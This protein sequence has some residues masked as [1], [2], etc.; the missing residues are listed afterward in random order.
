MVG[1]SAQSVLESS[2][3]FNEEITFANVSIASIDSAISSYTIKTN[4]VVIKPSATSD[5]TSQQPII[6]GSYVVYNNT[7]YYVVGSYL[8][9]DIDFTSTPIVDSINYLVS[10]SVVIFETSN[11]PSTAGELTI[12][13]VNKVGYKFVVESDFDLLT[14]I[15]GGY[16]ISYIVSTIE[17]DES[18]GGGADD[19]V[20]GEIVKNLT[21]IRTVGGTVSPQ[22]HVYSE[23]FPI[24]NITLKPYEN[25]TFIGL[26]INGEYVENSYNNLTLEVDLST[27]SRDIVV[28]AKFAKNVAIEFRIAVDNNESKEYIGSI[29]EGNLLKELFINGTI[30]NIYNSIN[31]SYVLGDDFFE[32]SS[33][34]TDI[35]IQANK[36]NLMFTITVP[37][38][39]KLHFGV[40][41]DKV[42]V[43]PSPTAYHFNGWYLLENES[44]STSTSLVSDDNYFDI[45]AIEKAQYDEHGN[46][47]ANSKKNTLSFVA[48]YSLDTTK[49]LLVTTSKVQVHAYDDTTYGFTTKEYDY[50]EFLANGTINSSLE[51]NNY[52]A[53]VDAETG[54]TYLF[55][56]WWQEINKD[57]SVLISSN[58]D[59]T[60]ALQGNC[61]ARFIEYRAITIDY[62]ED[63]SI[64]LEGNMHMSY[65]Y[66]QTAGETN[67]LPISVVSGSKIKAY[68]TVFSALTNVVINAENTFLFKGEFDDGHGGTVSKYEVSE[69][70]D[71]EFKLYGANYDDLFT[72][73]SNPAEDT[74]AHIRYKKIYED[75]D[76]YALNLIS[77]NSINQVLVKIQNN[78]NSFKVSIIAENTTISGQESSTQRF[79]AASSIIVVTN[80]ISQNNGLQNQFF[81]NTIKVLYVNNKAYYIYQPT[82]NIQSSIVYK[83]LASFKINQDK[84]SQ[85]AT[86]NDLFI[87]IVDNNNTTK[88]ILADIKDILDNGTTAEK[89]ALLVQLVGTD[90]AKVVITEDNYT[91]YVYYETVLDT[92]LNISARTE[93]YFTI[94]YRDDD[95]ALHEN[96]NVPISSNTIDRYYPRYTYITIT[97]AKEYRTESFVGFRISYDSEN[98]TFY[99]VSD[100]GYSFSFCVTE[101]VTVSAQF[102]NA[103]INVED[104]VTDSTIVS[105]GNG[106][107]ASS[108]SGIY[109]DDDPTNVVTKMIST[110][111]ANDYIHSI[112]MEFSYN[113]AMQIVIFQYDYGCNSFS[114]YSGLPISNIDNDQFKVSGLDYLSDSFG[115]KMYQLVELQ[116]PVAAE[117]VTV[118]VITVQYYQLYRMNITVMKNDSVEGCEGYNLNLYYPNDYYD[119]VITDGFALDGEYVNNLKLYQYIKNVL[120]AD[121]AIGMIDPQ[122]DNT[123][124]R[125]SQ[126]MT[127]NDFIDGFY[128]YTNETNSS[129]FKISGKKVMDDG[130][131][132]HY[133]GNVKTLVSGT[134]AYTLV[135]KFKT[136]GT[137]RIYVHPSYY[138]N[139][140]YSFTETNS[141][142]LPSITEYQMLMGSVLVGN[143][144]TGNNYQIAYSASES[145]LDYSIKRDVTANAGGE[146]PNFNKGVYYFDITYYFAEA[147]TIYFKSEYLAF[148][149]YYYQSSAS[150]YSSLHTALPTYP[151]IQLIDFGTNNSA[152]TMS[153]QEFVD[154]RSR[155]YGYANGDTDKLILH[156]DAKESIKATTLRFNFEENA[157]LGSVNPQVAINLSQGA[158]TFVPNDGNV[159]TYLSSDST[160]RT[161]TFTKTGSTDEI[162]ISYYSYTDTAHANQNCIKII[163]STDL[164]NKQTKFDVELL[165]FVVKYQFSGTDS[166]RARIEVVDF[167]KYSL[168]FK[169]VYCLNASQVVTKE[170]VSLSVGNHSKIYWTL[171]STFADNNEIVIET[172][173]CFYTLFS[174]DKAQTTGTSGEYLNGTDEVYKIMLSMYEDGKVGPTEV[175]A[176]SSTLKNLSIY[177]YV[178][179][180][181]AISVDAPGADSIFYADPSKALGSYTGVHTVNEASIT[182]DNV[183]SSLQTGSFV[184]Y[185]TGNVS[186]VNSLAN[187]Y[188]F[189]KGPDDGNANT[190]ESNGIFFSLTNVTTSSISYM[191]HPNTSRFYLA[192]YNGF[193]SSSSNK[194]ITGILAPGNSAHYETSGDF[195]TLSQSGANDNNFNFIFGIANRNDD[196]SYTQNASNE[197]FIYAQTEAFESHDSLYLDEGF[198]DPADRSS[199]M[200][201]TTFGNTEMTY[202]IYGGAVQYDILIKATIK[203]NKISSGYY[204]SSSLPAKTTFTELDYLYDATGNNIYEIVATPESGSYS[205]YYKIGTS[206]QYQVLNQAESSTSVAY[207]KVTTVP[208]GRMHALTLN[209]NGKEVFFIDGKIYTS[210]TFENGEAKL[211][212]S[213]TKDYTPAIDCLFFSVNYTEKTVQYSHTNTIEIAPYSVAVYKLKF[214]FGA[215]YVYGYDGGVLKLKKNGS[216]VNSGYSI[217]Y[218]NGLVLTL[219][220]GTS[221]QA[222]GVTVENPQAPEI[223]NCYTEAQISE[224]PEG[225]NYVKKTIKASIYDATYRELTFDSAKSKLIPIDEDTSLDSRVEIKYDAEIRKSVYYV[226][227]KDTSTSEIYRY[228]LKGNKLYTSYDCLTEANYTSD[229]TSYYGSGFNI[230]VYYKS[231]NVG[232]IN[233]ARKSATISGSGEIEYKKDTISGNEF[234]YKSSD[235]K[236]YLKGQAS[237]YTG[238]YSLENAFIVVTRGNGTTLSIDAKTEEIKVNTLYAADDTGFKYYVGGNSLYVDYPFENKTKVDTSSNHKYDYNGG[239]PK[240][241]ILD[242]LER[243]RYHIASYIIYPATIKYNGL[244]YTPQETSLTSSSSRVDYKAGSETI[245]YEPSTQKVYTSSSVL[246]PTDQLSLSKSYKVCYSIKNETYYSFPTTITYITGTEILTLSLTNDISLVNEKLV[247][248]EDG[249]GTKYR[250][251]VETT[252]LYLVNA[253]TTTTLINQNKYIL[254]SELRYICITSGAPSETYKNIKASTAADFIGDIVTETVVGNG[255]VPYTSAKVKSITTSAYD[256][257]YLKGF[258]V[259]TDVNIAASNSMW[260]NYKEDAGAS[261]PL[262]GLQNYAYLS[263]FEYCTFFS[264]DYE[265][266]KNNAVDTPFTFER[267]ANGVI[268]SITFNCSIPIFGNLKIF[269]VYS[270]IIYSIDV[271]QINLQQKP[272]INGEPVSDEGVVG[273]ADGKYPLTTLYRYYF[274]ANYDEA[275]CGYVKGQ[276][277]VEYEGDAWIKARAYNGN[278]FLGYSIGKKSTLTT[279]N[280]VFAPN[281]VENG[282]DISEIKEAVTSGASYADTEEYN[283]AMLNK[284]TS[285]TPSTQYNE[286]YFLDD[287]VMKY[288][289]TTNSYIQIDET[290]SK[291]SSNNIFMFAITNDV[292]INFYYKAVQYE[293][294]LEL[295]DIE[296][297]FYTD[298]ESGS[299]EMDTYISYTDEYMEESSKT[300]G[301]GSWTNPAAVDQNNLRQPEFTIPAQSDALA[302]GLNGNTALIINES[303]TPVTYKK[304]DANDSLVYTLYDSTGK[305]LL[306]D[307]NSNVVAQPQPILSRT[308]DWEASDAAGFLVYKEVTGIPATDSATCDRRYIPSITAIQGQSLVRPAGPG[309]E[310]SIKVAGQSLTVNYFTKAYTDSN[311]ANK[312]LLLYTT[313]YKNQLYVVRETLYYH[314]ADMNGS[315]QNAVANVRKATAYYLYKVITYGSMDTYLE[316]NAAYF[317]ENQ[318]GNKSKGLVIDGSI[319]TDTSNGDVRVN[320]NNK[321]IFSIFTI[322]E[323]TDGTFTPVYNSEGKVYHINTDDVVWNTTNVGSA[324]Y[325]FLTFK[326]QVTIDGTAHTMAVIAS[327]GAYADASTFDKDWSKYTAKYISALITQYNANGGDISTNIYKAK[328]D[329]LIQQGIIFVSEVDDVVAENGMRNVSSS[330][331]NRQILDYSTYFVISTD[332]FYRNIYTLKEGLFSINIGGEYTITSDQFT[333]SADM[334]NVSVTSSITG[335]TKQFD[336]GCEITLNP[337]GEGKLVA[338]IKISIKIFYNEQGSLPSVKIYSNTADLKQD[339]YLNTTLYNLTVYGKT[340]DYTHM[341][342]S[343]LIYK[344]VSPDELNGTNGKRSETG[345]SFD[346]R[347]ITSHVE[348][349]SFFGHIYNA[350]APNDEFF[351]L[352]NLN[353]KVSIVY[354]QSLMKVNPQAQFATDEPTKMESQVRD[355]LGTNGRNIYNDSAGS[356]KAT[357]QKMFIANV[358]KGGSGVYT[359]AGVHSEPG[360]IFQ[361]Y[362]LYVISD[363][364]EIMSML[365][366]IYQNKRYS[367]EHRRDAL[368]YMSYINGFNPEN[369]AIASS[370]GGKTVLSYPQYAFSNHGNCKTYE[371]LYTFLRDRGMNLINLPTPEQVTENDREGAKYMRVRSV[372]IMRAAAYGVDSNFVQ[373]HFAQNDIVVSC[374]QLPMMFQRQVMYKSDSWPKVNDYYA[375][376]AYTYYYAANH[377]V[378]CDIENDSFVWSG[379]PADTVLAGTSNNYVENSDGSSE[380]TRQAKLMKS[381]KYV[382][383]QLPSNVFTGLMRL[384][385]TYASH[386]QQNSHV[387]PYYAFVDTSATLSPSDFSKNRTAEGSDVVTGVNMIIFVDDRKFDIEDNQDSYDK[388]TMDNRIIVQVFEFNPEPGYIAAERLMI[389]AMIVGTI[390]LLA[391]SIFTGGTSTA[392]AVAM[393]VSFG[394]GTALYVGGTVSLIYSSCAMR[395]DNLTPEIYQAVLEMYAKGY[396]RQEDGSI[397]FNGLSPDI[398]EDEF[399]NLIPD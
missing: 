123:G 242:D 204:K 388:S 313:T 186:F 341:T 132:Y 107:N 116:Y 7:I 383:S 161:L 345:S 234:V 227:I 18:Y 248:Y 286:V 324:S 379:A 119:T 120:F 385:N 137:I 63:S 296:T 147:L 69:L 3:N 310:G 36:Q 344:P 257:Y 182:T 155:T 336:T 298:P 191:W 188:L 340:V 244:S 387:V 87:E 39:T 333:T 168:E 66:I 252:A 9:E 352:P 326:E 170:N 84:N 265:V 146:N 158:S 160:I 193:E 367:K 342:T 295:G 153:Y 189:L 289:S 255:D 329:L 49:P 138:K 275:S 218:L 8:Y 279:V 192:D 100:V 93:S 215:N 65:G 109:G 12:V 320:T 25:Y 203:G 399:L 299:A 42:E 395:G 270:P 284:I 338:T 221:I 376:H 200:K 339:K 231:I 250:Y 346:T 335:L 302:A 59:E 169:N 72:I 92:E 380:P 16:T 291:G 206:G 239:N 130:E 103:V 238:D 184:N 202:Y 271:S 114:V 143:L 126:T 236:L 75:T 386:L 217:E 290:L 199:S 254:R 124:T 159:L 297:G 166:T 282:T 366:Q 312:E 241:F 211:D 280:T 349:G 319:Y 99:K 398:I 195:G 293:L 98:S 308:I 354:T 288:D 237:A 394:V 301:T 163:Y 362:K 213:L 31:A 83:N 323:Q 274:A 246:I 60:G 101:S 300:S 19:I 21:S 222:S 314:A 397:K 35:K 331:Y 317:E 85:T 51:L 28:E 249:A 152:I 26:Y 61:I 131:N 105:G 396:E 127:T 325:S 201:F 94:T 73:S 225:S 197:A 196:V 260:L 113:G 381:N 52:R 78:Y 258:V 240:G 228:Y 178:R 353:V 276:L 343:D 32:S 368:M 311:G 378:T 110:S 125:F 330:N 259:F 144:N 219:A 304:V 371:E 327:Y 24:L 2:L 128:A 95:N 140:I 251:N 328:Y 149:R 141:A 121:T 20:G 134:V 281:Y 122:I 13:S 70:I 268:L 53:F 173:K 135:Y 118:P 307:E 177:A 112:R 374:V 58:F 5:V 306:N 223:I 358:Y 172:K 214:N 27:Y 80:N 360:F 334:Q 54:A 10:N 230:K 377:Y 294:E 391:A 292:H 361:S 243:A 34:I 165:N 355:M 106:G 263:K 224:L 111:T 17:G 82:K 187:A 266:F 357:I 150:E 148:D 151:Q 50:L 375:D 209:Y 44:I 89:Q 350:G 139:G 176:T 245:K 1:G 210:Y 235:G 318:Y 253:D 81:A 269:A 71:L 183:Y 232:G 76:Q 86:D 233:L 365:N 181:D 337:Y 356:Q 62:T 37:Y 303:S 273:L 97:L 14:I 57:M 285:P 41:N 67:M 29:D 156:L 351:D 46:V 261:P 22:T 332:E 79:N 91:L 278:V 283:H 262:T 264:I 373:R 43:N 164:I 171:G 174:R 133:E 287:N 6:N 305:I 45:Y 104:A 15:N 208:S 390:G 55:T 154:L 77:G 384:D 369:Y 363:A 30:T 145:D 175:I 309:Q 272:T 392:A 74:D 142:L 117:S 316:Y 382:Y 226:E 47:I 393:W 102:V 212:Y 372:D 364:Y 198:D 38:G 40:Q 88:L 115:Q 108:S 347:Y 348:V 321:Y 220:D 162:S 277:L 56:G 64:S 207:F 90:D 23:T 205:S 185:G 136:Q 33:S 229:L 247:V 322:Q 315:G 11:N 194:V 359:D 370:T 96:E 167:K 4:M 48:K 129:E 157:T 256:G 216:V 389:G 180:G 68:A 179:D 267:D 190:N